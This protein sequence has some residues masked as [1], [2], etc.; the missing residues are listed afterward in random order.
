MVG[1]LRD[2]GLV[3]LVLVY[4]LFSITV[5][6]GI[7]ILFRYADQLPLLKYLQLDSLENLLARLA[8]LLV[9]LS[10]FLVVYHL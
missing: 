10:V 7:S 1:K 3:L 6:P 9:V 8:S 2:L 5:L 4:F